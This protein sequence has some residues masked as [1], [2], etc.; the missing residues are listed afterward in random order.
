MLTVAQMTKKAPIL[1]IG[2]GERMHIDPY[3]LDFSHPVGRLKEA[4]QIIRLCF[5]G[6]GRSTS[7]ATISP[8]TTP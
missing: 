2:A 4:L 8:S 6:S 7:R 3:G 5:A 1:G